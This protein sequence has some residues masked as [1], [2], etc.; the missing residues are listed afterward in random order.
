MTRPTPALTA[1]PHASP[2]ERVHGE[3]QLVQWIHETRDAAYLGAD[4]FERFFMI[5]GEKM[6]CRIAFYWTD[7]ADLEAR[8]R[9][10]ECIPV[11][12]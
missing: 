5:G 6:L 1:Q 8:I 2:R 7:K 12:E 9:S 11:Q 10:L 4:T 3:E